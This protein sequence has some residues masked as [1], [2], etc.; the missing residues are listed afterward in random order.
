MQALTNEY[1]MLNLKKIIKIAFI[2]WVIYS[3][4]SLIYFAHTL[5]EDFEHAERAEFMKWQGLGVFILIL[6]A[7]LLYIEV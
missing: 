7:Y 1:W 5:N 4:L 6:V 3:F 2:P